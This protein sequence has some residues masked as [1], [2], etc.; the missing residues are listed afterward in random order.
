MSEP[1]TPSVSTFTLDEI[2]ALAAIG[3]LKAAGVTPSRNLLA[4]QCHWGNKKASAVFVSLVEAGLCEPAHRGGR[5]PEPDPTPEEIRE[6]KFPYRMR[7]LAAVLC[8]PGPASPPRGTPRVVRVLVGKSTRA[9]DN[10][11]DDGIYGLAR[12]D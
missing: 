12:G 2:R 4:R 5:P 11:P 3:R 1:A 6:R 9:R 7:K 10:D 8:G